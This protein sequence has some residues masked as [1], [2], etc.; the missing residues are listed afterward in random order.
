MRKRLTGF[1]RLRRDLAADEQQHQHRHERDAEQRG[2]EHREGLGEGER[3][4]QPAFLR[5][6]ARRPG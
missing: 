6:R 3:L 1:L 2:E 4:E 5:R